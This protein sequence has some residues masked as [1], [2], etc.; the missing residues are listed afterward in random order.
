M[1]TDGFGVI[2][3]SFADEPQSIRGQQATIVSV[4]AQLL[5]ISNLPLS[6]CLFHNCPPNKNKRAV[7]AFRLHRKSSFYTARAV[8]TPQEQFLHRNG[9]LF[10]YSTVLYQTQYDYFKKTAVDTFG[11]LF[12]K[13]AH[14]LYL[15]LGGENLAVFGHTLSGFYLLLHLITRFEQIYQLILSKFVFISNIIA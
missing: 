5:I 11:F 8:F 14:C 15:T 2:V 9:I 3:I 1:P 6:E 4:A 12:Y 10:N 13:V 7:P